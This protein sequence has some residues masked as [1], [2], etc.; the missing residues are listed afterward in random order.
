LLEAEDVDAA[1]IDPGGGRES[2]RS[3]AMRIRR[4]EVEGDCI[5]KDRVEED[6]SLSVVDDHYRK[7]CTFE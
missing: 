5:T 1:G 6:V 7:R 4:I 2:K 3:S